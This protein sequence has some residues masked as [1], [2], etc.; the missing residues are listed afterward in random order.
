M[1]ARPSRG[2]GC[3]HTE[4][5]NFF[6]SHRAPEEPLARTLLNLWHLCSSVGHSHSLPE[7]VYWWCGMSCD[8]CFPTVHPQKPCHN[9]QGDRLGIGCLQWSFEVLSVSWCKMGHFCIYVI[10]FNPKKRIND[11]IPSCITQTR[12]KHTELWG[13]EGFGDGQGV[14]TNGTC[15]TMFLKSL[16]TWEEKKMSK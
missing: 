9:P 8:E 10:M 2:Y 3:G 1:S 11:F 4:I 6:G 12:G 15:P 14:V 7:V 5:G 16:P 13:L